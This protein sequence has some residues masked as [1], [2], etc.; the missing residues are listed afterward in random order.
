[1]SSPDIAVFG[2]KDYKRSRRAYVLES[3]FEYFIALLVSDS[4]LALLLSSLGMTDSMIGII[5]SIVSLAFLFEFLSIFVVQKIINTKR[6]AIIFHTS[7]QIFFLSLYLIPFIPALEKYRIPAV[8]ICIL[9]AYFGNYFVTSVIYKWSNSYVD[10]HKRAE[11][12]AVKE[13]TALISGIAIT[14]TAGYIMGALCDSGNISS[15]F[16]FAAVSILIFSI[17]DFVCLMLLKN[18][19]KPKPDKHDAVPLRTVFHET[20]CNRNFVNVVILASLWKIACYTTVGFLGTYKNFLY[21][22]AAVQV[23]NG[24]ANLCRFALSKPFG[25]FSDKHSYATGIRLGLIIASCAFG[26]NVFTTPQTRW[27]II[28]YMV[29]YCISTAGT[30]QNLRNIVYSY[31][32]NKYFVQATAIKNSISGLCGFGAS[33]LAGK[34]LSYIQSNNNTFLGIQV[35]GQQVLSLITFLIVILAILFTKLVIEKQKVIMQ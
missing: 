15:W 33:I 29:L 6:F 20:L 7:S 30:E 22:V 24:T 1:M 19:I 18:D 35:Y 23:I 2:S 11:F 10:P 32:D 34:L 8:I 21:S 28:I 12:S 16:I 5:S 17:C 3:T 4:F 9:I 13:M 26:I 31:V 14:V 27:L 25:R